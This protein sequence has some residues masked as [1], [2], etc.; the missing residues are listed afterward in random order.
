[1][2]NAFAAVAA[3]VAIVTAFVIAGMIILAPPVAAQEKPNRIDL[4][5]F[6]YWEHQMAKADEVDALQVIDQNVD[7]TQPLLPMFR[8]Q[9]K[10]INKFC[11]E[12]QNPP[13]GWLRSNGF[14]GLTDQMAKG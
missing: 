14:C 10:H 12:E 13:E 3:F 6:A 11:E 1:M 5:A 8:T 2:S 7:D 9:F 4:A